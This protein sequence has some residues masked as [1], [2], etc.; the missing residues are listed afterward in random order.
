MLVDHGE[1]QGG[2]R[3]Q[4]IQE[5]P[6]RR[7]GALHPG[8]RLVFEVPEEGRASR[9][10][11]YET[12]VGELGDVDPRQLGESMRRLFRGQAAT[13]ALRGHE[14]SLGELQ[15]LFF[16]VEMQRDPRNML[17]SMMLTERMRNRGGHSPEFGLDEAVATHPAVPEGHLQ[18]VRQLDEDAQRREA[19]ERRRNTT[20]LREIR[21]RQI[22]TLRVWFRAELAA[23]RQPVSNSLADLESFLRS[24]IERWIRQRTE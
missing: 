12:L 6:D 1:V 21:R 3:V 9:Y 14:G 2:G 8:D 24:F 10:H 13:S 19:G 16:G 23:G 15:G 4:S 17:A 22:A 5:V 7:G 11:D 20:H 18:A